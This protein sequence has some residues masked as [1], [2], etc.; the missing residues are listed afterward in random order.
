[1]RVHSKETKNRIRIAHIGLKHKPETIEKIRQ[2]NL[3]ENNPHWKGGITPHNKKIRDSN[4]HKEWRLAIFQRD[5]Y[6]CVFCGVK[7]GWHKDIKIRIRLEAD[8]I[9]PFYLFPELR[10]DLDNG[11]TLCRDCHKQ[12][13]TFGVNQY[14]YREQFL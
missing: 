11:R 13:D 2:A 5:N 6:S 4:G 14:N 1:M 12:T 10:F 3:G 8:H 7:G 9:K